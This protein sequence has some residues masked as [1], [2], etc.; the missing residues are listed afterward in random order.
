[1]HFRE[2][3]GGLERHPAVMATALRSAVAGGGL[4]KLYRL[5]SAQCNSGPG[6]GC[7]PAR[8]EPS[9]T[10]NGAGGPDRAEP[11]HGGRCYSVTLTF[12]L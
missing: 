12:C 2:R 7:G 3:G 4:V 8:A 10:L 6:Y 11:L 9:E 5:L 1:M